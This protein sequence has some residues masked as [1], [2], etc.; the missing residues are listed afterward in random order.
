MLAILFMPVFC[1]AEEQ[2]ITGLTAHDIVDNRQSLDLSP[3]MKHRLLSNMR[4]QLS[5][6]RNIIGML[7]HDNF[8][9]A[10]NTA[11]AK[12]GMTEGLEQVYNASNNQELIKLG[13]I[14]SAS[15]DKLAISLKSKDLKKSL[16]ALRESM[17][18]CVQCHNKFRQ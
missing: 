17:A 4:E 6:T 2:G 10:S 16:K 3:R 14:A 8:E 12:L 5:A 7:G 1:T 15:A 13:I 18:I 9:G 11:R